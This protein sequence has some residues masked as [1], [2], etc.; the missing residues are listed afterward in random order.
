[1]TA[2]ATSLPSVPHR[3]ALL[4]SPK[5]SVFVL[6]DGGDVEMLGC[7]SSPNQAG[8]G[9]V[10]LGPGFQEQADGNPG[11]RVMARRGEILSISPFSSSH[12]LAFLQVRGALEKLK[13]YFK[14]K[15]CCLSR[16]CPRNGC[17]VGTCW[18]R[19]GKQ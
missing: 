13:L 7:C 17:P 6:Q 8:S 5:G 11:S 9:V 19:T 2:T 16:T 12:T 4:S 18:E 15:S 1:M 14:H 3:G 10:E